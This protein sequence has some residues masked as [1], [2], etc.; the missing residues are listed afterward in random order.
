MRSHDLNRLLDEPGSERR[1]G[2][3]ENMYLGSAPVWSFTG[4]MWATP[5]ASCLPLRQLMPVLFVGRS[6]LLRIAQIQGKPAPQLAG[7]DSRYPC[8][9]AWRLHDQCAPSGAIGVG[10]PSEHPDRIRVRTIIITAPQQAHRIG[11]RCLTHAAARPGAHLSSTCSK[12]IKRLQLGCKRSA[13]PPLRVGANQANADFFQFQGR[14]SWSRLLG[15]VGNF[16]STSQRYA[17]GSTPLSLQVSMM[18]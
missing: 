18:L 10:M 3:T 15:Q 9:R 16:S 14:S 4:R 12:A 1:P 2:R 7:A 17:K 13:N 6:M 11:A 8:R 5:P